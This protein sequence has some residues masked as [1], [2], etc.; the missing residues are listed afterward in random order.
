V[1]TGWKIDKREFPLVNWLPT[2]I[3]TDIDSSIISR[4]PSTAFLYSG[5]HSAKRN[6]L[7][8]GPR[9]LVGSSERLFNFF[10]TDVE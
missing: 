1:L 6:I 8:G 3:S 4:F 5:S 2:E 10:V 9:R 7:S